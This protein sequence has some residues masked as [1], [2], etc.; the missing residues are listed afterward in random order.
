MANLR[1]SQNLEQWGNLLVEFDALE[2]AHDPQLIANTEVLLKEFDAK[3]KEW[4]AEQELRADNFN[5]LG[6]MKLTRD[7]LCNSDTLRLPLP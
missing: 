2:S 6:T 3:E 1:E 7:E 5:V 4:L